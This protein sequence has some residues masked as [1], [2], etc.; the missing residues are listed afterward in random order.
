MGDKT[1]IICA[2]VIAY[3]GTKIV[4]IERLA[5]NGTGLLALPGGKQDPGESLSLTAVRE[6]MEETGLVFVYSGVLGTYAEEER[7]PRGRFV[8]TIF[9]GAA[10]GTPRNEN[11]KT[12]VHLLEKE[13]ILTLEDKFAF[14]HFEILEDF[15]R[16]AEKVMRTE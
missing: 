3:Y 12:R 8:S 1:C 4:L 6:L 16:Y 14:D 9:M 10:Y 7:D 13:Q 11:G 5:G 2:D 15:F